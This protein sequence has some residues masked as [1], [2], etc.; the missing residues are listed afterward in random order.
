MI[1]DTLGAVLV[2]SSAKNVYR[3]EYQEAIKLQKLAQEYGCC[4]LIIHHTYKGDGKDAVQRASGS[5]GLTGAVRERSW[6]VRRSSTGR[7]SLNVP[8]RRFDF[9]IGET[10]ELN[11]AIKFSS[12]GRCFGID[13]DYVATVGRKQSLEIT[14]ELVTAR[15]R[16]LGAGVNSEWVISFEIPPIGRLRLISVES[17]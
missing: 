9:P 6:S 1:L 15:I 2:L 7:R 16:L 11:V 10:R 14:E 4:L 3:Q 13:N 17:S 12:D 8:L 5:H